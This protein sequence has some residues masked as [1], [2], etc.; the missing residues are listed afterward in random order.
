MLYCWFVDSV[1]VSAI[2]WEE[3][4]EFSG[5]Y[6]LHVH[7]SCA[8]KCPQCADCDLLIMTLGYSLGTIFWGL[9]TKQWSYSNTRECVICIC[10]TCAKLYHLTYEGEGEGTVQPLMKVFHDTA[11]EC[12]LP[13]G[14]TQRITTSYP[15]QV[16]TPHLNPSHTGQYSIYLPGRARRDGRLSWPSWL[17]TVAPRPGVEPFDHDHST[18]VPPRQLLCITNLKQTYFHMAFALHSLK[19]GL[20]ETV[21]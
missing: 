17:D 2:L 4:Y 3:D 16:N 1:A 6:D 7:G 8:R 14:I 18:T 10:G 13:H 19:F 11:T 9:G 12:L 15:T 20:V 21:L 5:F